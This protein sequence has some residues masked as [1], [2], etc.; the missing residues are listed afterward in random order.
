MIISISIVILA[1]RVIIITFL[2]SAMGWNMNYLAMERV[3]TSEISALLIQ[4][5]RRLSPF[6]IPRILI[7]MASGHVSMKYG[8]QVCIC[9]FLYMICLWPYN[10]PNLV[11]EQDFVLMPITVV[12]RMELRV[13]NFSSLSVRSFLGNKK[14]ELE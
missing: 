9:I 8:F 12:I 14:L 6:F 3:M 4:R 13:H 1:H 10:D 5:L 7:N 11:K 2:M